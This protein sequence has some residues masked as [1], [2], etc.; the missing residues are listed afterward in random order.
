LFI[1]ILMTPRYKSIEEDIV[2][3]K[4]LIEKGIYQAATFDFA[5]IETQLEWCTELRR[6]IVE[7]INHPSTI[8][9]WFKVENECQIQ[10][11]DKLIVAC[12]SILALRPVRVLT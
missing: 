2:R 7:W 12:Q 3:K 9:S 10:D 4:E 1:S 11:V 8:E 6:D 5:C